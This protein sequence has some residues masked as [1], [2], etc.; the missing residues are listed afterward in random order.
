M[1]FAFDIEHAYN[2]CK[3]EIENWTQWNTV[4]VDFFTSL[5]TYF[6]DISPYSSM[7]EFI[8]TVEPRVRSTVETYIKNKELPYLE[9]LASNYIENKLPYESELVDKVVDEIVKQFLDQLAKKLFQ[10]GEK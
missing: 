1:P 3:D 4:F 10:E 8:K 7:D 9:S 5:I 6:V 2:L